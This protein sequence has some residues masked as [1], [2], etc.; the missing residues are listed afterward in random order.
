MSRFAEIANKVA[1][2]IERPKM[3]PPGIYELRVTN[4]PSPVTQSYASG[5]FEKV[6]FNL[7]G[8]NVY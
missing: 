4:T 7:I 3:A 8:V 2:E 6:S 1:A 5:S